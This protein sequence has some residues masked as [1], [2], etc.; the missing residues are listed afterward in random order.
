MTTEKHAIVL[1]TDG[2]FSDLNFRMESLRSLQ[3]AVGGWVQAVDFRDDLTMWVNEEGKLNNL[4]LNPIATRIWTHFFGETDFIV[5][6]AVFTGGT[7]ENGDTMFI[8]EEAETL[9]KEL[10]KL[11]TPNLLG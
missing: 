6:N 2:N 1:D 5:G 9:L 8:G 11:E 4:P 10:A 3:E 7:D